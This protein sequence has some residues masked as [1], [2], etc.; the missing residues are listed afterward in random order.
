[1]SLI[2]GQIAGARELSDL[3]W[4]ITQSEVR[5][6]VPPKSLEFWKPKHKQRPYAIRVTPLD[7]RFK[8]VRRGLPNFLIHAV[9]YHAFH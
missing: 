1:M 4:L 2:G 9:L 3:G 8:E 7:L 6:R 5:L